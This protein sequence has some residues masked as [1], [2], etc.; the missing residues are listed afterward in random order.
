MIDFKI[1]ILIALLAFFY[2]W[3]VTIISRRNK[4]LEALSGIDVQLKKRLDLIPNI[5]TIAKK[6]MQHEEKIFLEVTALREGL[7]K[8]YDAKDAAAVENYLKLSA[9][10]EEKMQGLMLRAESYPE[11]RSSENMALSQQTYNEV[12]EQIAAARRFYNAAVNSL[13]NSIEI[14]PGNIFAKIINV[15]AM[16]FF[17]GSE[18]AKKEID[19]AKFL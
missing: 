16:P 8:N 3:Y 9:Q 12:E 5:L 4:V 2:F 11:L 14:F 18:A 17:E 7:Q 6:F 10:L 19:A 15:K 1:I 13:K